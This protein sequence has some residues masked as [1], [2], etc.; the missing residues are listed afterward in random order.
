MKYLLALLV[1]LVI[2]V[3][4]VP[5][6]IQEPGHVLITYADVSIETTVT[7]L[8]ITIVLALVVLSILYRLIKLALGFPDF[9]FQRGQQRF[10]E[11][12]QKNFYQGLTEL[13]SGHWRQAE[14]LLV[15][16]TEGSEDH[17]LAYLGAAR[18]AQHQGEHERR[19][20]Y[21]KCAHGISADTVLAAGLTQA[22]LQ[23][24]QGQNERALATLSH[25]SHAHHNNPYLLELL[26]QLY[27]Q[28]GEWVRLKDDLP[29]L[30][31]AGVIDKERAAKLEVEASLQLLRNNARQGGIGKVLAEWHAL[32]DKLK[33]HVTL[34]RE[35]ASQLLDLQAHDDAERIL[36]KAIGH[37]W[38]NELVML[39]GQVKSQDA[40]AQLAFA[41]SWPEGYTQDARV[42]LALARICLHNQ[43]LGTARFHLETCVE[44]GAGAEAY[45]ELATLLDQL[46]DHNA[47]QHCYQEGLTRAVKRE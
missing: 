35:C 43:L 45:F 44:M 15:S 5:M 41:Q 36:K 2:A 27:L 42:Q 10:R 11:R 8:I 25:L 23:M 30:I 17:L 14:K 28:L 32:P 13:A 24:R 9:M 40:Q 37:H 4:V 39:Y 7:F 26:L 12:G 3:S 16:S 34:V 38:N 18:A 1:V 29:E 22:E 21:L 6:L 31:K 20:H 33:E 19:D 46:N 47:A